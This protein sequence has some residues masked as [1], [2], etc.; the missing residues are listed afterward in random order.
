MNK[1][2]VQIKKISDI[3]SR[4]LRKGDDFEVIQ[5]LDTGNI[6][7]NNIHNLQILKIEKD[8][9]PSRAKRRVR[10][11]TIIYSTVRP[12][13]EHYGFLENPDNNLIVSTGFATI[14]IIDKNIDPKFIY[15]LIT[16]KQITDYIHGIGINA[17]SSYPSIKPE[18]IGNLKFVIP[19]NITDQKSISSI[20]NIIDEKIE[21]NNKINNELEKIARTLYDYWFVQFD[22]PDENGRPYRSSG[23]KMVWSEDL[24][25]EIPNGWDVS[26][27]GEV[28]EIYQPQTISEK[29]C[30]EDGKY[31]V[32]GSNGIIGKYNKYNHEESEII[33]SCRGN[34]GNIHRTLPKV[35]ITGNAMVFKM[36][37]KNINNEF[38]YQALYY[39]GIKNISSGSVQSQIT[40]T[41]VAPLKI[42]I[43]E[44][45][46]LDKFSGIAKNVV[47]KKL[48]IQ[49]ENQSL[50][51][52]RDFLLPMLMNGQIS[53]K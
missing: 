27:L 35:W 43:P 32:H 16:Q 23:G 33:I 19:K 17:T 8:K 53:I 50:F 31:F 47:L 10:K 51:Q 52:L 48:S 12:N 2:I 28:C 21:L 7:K 13:Q 15:Y 9:I 37:D 41:N 18:D 36:K 29:D 46:I 39:S 6:T 45:K 34:C 26:K 38:L 25:R 14:D 3:N 30:V 40:R 44:K 4:S 49:D 20:L 24:K 22:F 1:R 5:Y 42:I 11:N